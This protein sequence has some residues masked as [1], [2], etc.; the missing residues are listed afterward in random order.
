LLL[1]FT[2]IIPTAANTTSKLVFA[3]QF[4]EHLGVLVLPHVVQ[5]DQQ[6]RFMY[7][8]KRV[9]GH[10]VADHIDQV[11]DLEKQLLKLTDE[12]S[13]PH[14]TKKFSKAARNAAALYSELTE[15]KLKSLVIPYVQSRI[16]KCLQ[17]MQAHEM[18]LHFKGDKENP[19]DH[20]PIYIARDTARAVFHFHHDDDGLRYHLSLRHHDTDISLLVPGSLVLV[21]QPGWV[22]IGNMVYRLQDGVDGNKARPFFHKEF[23][24]IPEASAE[25]YYRGFMLKIIQNYETRLQ[26]IRLDIESPPCQPVLKL[27]EDLEGHPVLTLSFRY[28]QKN[29]LASDHHACWTDLVA[30]A[31]GQYFRKTLRDPDAEE[32]YINHLLKLGL[33]SRDKR[34]FYLAGNTTEVTDD[35]AGAVSTGV[36]GGKLHEAG[37][38]SL[39]ALLEWLGTH[40]QSLAAKGLIIRQDTKGNIYYTG[41]IRAD[42]DVSTGQ[43][44]F[45]VHAMAVF[46]EVRIPFIRLKNHLLNGIREYEL[47]DGRVAILPIEWFSRYKDLLLFSQSLDTAFRLKKHHFTVVDKLQNGSIGIPA[48]TVLTDETR[49]SM[50][51]LPPSLHHT[52]RPYQ[53]SGFAWMHWLNRN[54]LGGCLADDMGLGKTLQTLALLMKIKADCRPEDTIARQQRSGAQLSLFGETEETD[55]YT[56]KTSLIVMPLSLIYN[57]ENEIRKFTPGLRYHK[58]MGAGRESEIKNLL[59]YDIVLTTYGI[60]RNDVEMLKDIAFH[61]LILDESQ[62]IKNPKSLVSAAVNSLHAQHRLVLTGTPIENSL[63]DLWSQLSFVNPGMLGS[64]TMF[65]KEF[66][67]PIQ[68]QGD[69]AKKEQLNNMIR[70][71]ILR[72]TKDLVE[73]DLPELSEKV[74]YC[75]MNDGQRKLYE[76]RK[77]E[78]RNRIF[79]AMTSGDKAGLRIHILQSLLHLRLIANHPLLVNHPDDPSGKFEEAVRMIGNLVAENHKVLIFSQFVKHLQLFRDHFDANQ[80]GYAWLTGQQKATERTSVIEAFQHDPQKQL[81]L[82]SLRAGGVGLNLTRADYVFM[83]DPW[84]N[85]AVEQQA[86][87]RAHR[88]GQQRHV[89]AYKFITRNSVEE[90]I[91]RLQQAKST[92]AGDFTG[93]NNPFKVFTDEEI[94]EIFD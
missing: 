58:Y 67:Q 18:P 31:E 65:R 36:A 33:S 80:L 28:G 30:D 47:P 54:G 75:E 59:E 45:D 69:E 44:W 3:I 55:K 84:W 5:E 82:I 25:K 72:R 71:F 42:I 37:H 46:G 53:R 6:G 38:P 23:V 27:E 52:L 9:F 51:D 77:S 39:Y 76:S 41:S 57:W 48:L 8:V 20:H 17:I 73:R 10:T 21:E 26:G 85:P 92:L 93:T 7:G 2:V 90:K 24:A 13:D 34:L 43:D 4:H 86:I 35:Q 49:I 88:I 60:M 68:D 12:C 70:P 74:H 94:L 63:D 81:F 19:V 79:D 40:E 11:S 91:L 78:M 87:S 66:V 89:F 64:L 16:S 50:P 56:G 1:K 32:N 62:L 22:L 14:L 29:C 61:Y 83:L 15:S